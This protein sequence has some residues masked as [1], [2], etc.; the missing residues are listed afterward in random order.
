MRRGQNGSDPGQVTG[1]DQGHRV[2]DAGG[3]GHHV[4]HPAAQ[5]RR[6]GLVIEGVRQPRRRRIEG[7]WQ[8]LGEVTDAEE[9]GGPLA[10]L[11]A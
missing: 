5:G 4:T 8:E 1:A 7:V 11:A 9:A 2:A 6:Q 10:L 3:L